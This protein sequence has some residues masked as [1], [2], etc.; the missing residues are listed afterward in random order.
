MHAH[1]AD[2][3]WCLAGA[4][5]LNFLLIFYYCVFVFPPISRADKSCRSCFTVISS[6]LVPWPLPLSISLADTDTATLCKS[7]PLKA[8]GLWKHHAGF[9]FRFVIPR[10]PLFFNWETGLH[11][12]LS[13]GDF[14]RRER[15]GELRKKWKLKVIV[16]RAQTTHTHS[17]TRMEL[18]VSAHTSIV[19]RLTLLHLYTHGPIHTRRPQG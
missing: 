5:W 6:H 15:W 1:K 9:I 11:L 17:H 4:M 12:N 16:F 3:A 18:T 7:M 10:H 14:K 13:E 8:Y 2:G 19:D